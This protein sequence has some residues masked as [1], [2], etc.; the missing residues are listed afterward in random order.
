M[1]ETASGRSASAPDKSKVFGAARR[2]A[3]IAAL[4]ELCHGHR[5]LD[6]LAAAAAVAFGDERFPVASTE[7]GVQ[8]LR[9]PKLGYLECAGMP[10]A[11]I[12]LLEAATRPLSP[13]DRRAWL[14][15]QYAII[16]PCTDLRAG[17]GHGLQQTIRAFCAP[18]LGQ[19]H[20]PAD[21]AVRSAI[22]AA[23]NGLAAGNE[24]AIRGPAEIAALGAASPDWLRRG[25][26]AHHLAVLG[27]LTMA[28]QPAPP[29]VLRHGEDT[30]E[31]LI[32]TGR[33]AADLRGIVQDALLR[34]NPTLAS[35]IGS[36]QGVLGAETIRLA[37]RGADTGTIRMVMDW[38]PDA[39]AM[40]ADARAAI[41]NQILDQAEARET[42]SIP[43]ADLA[44]IYEA[45]VR[46][47]DM[48]RIGLGPDGGE[49]LPAAEISWRRQIGN[50][51][52][53]PAL[54][55]GQAL[56]RE[57][58]EQIRARIRAETPAPGPTP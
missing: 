5:V 6:E 30:L 39:A 29:A 24:A 18:E 38:G 11:L 35:V 55:A 15:E 31:T 23:A 44:E 22:L 28:E 50:A 40:T 12:L 20:A 32:E 14:L 16:A 51:V 37:M 9:R 46:V 53:F 43:V 42:V 52:E 21:E 48:T 2:A 19:A 57:I 54:Q 45:L 27:R 41:V 10:A 58:R 1:E 8:A 7:A 56:P 3:M 17:A 25:L 34:A 26:A 47:G 33:D 36:D 4:T 49:K 13:D